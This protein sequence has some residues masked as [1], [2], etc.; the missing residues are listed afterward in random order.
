[1]HKLNLAQKTE[2]DLLFL[3]VEIFS[4]ADFLKNHKLEVI[5]LFKF[6]QSILVKTLDLPTLMATKIRAVFH[7]KWEK[8]DKSGKTL[9]KAKG[10]DYF[11]LMWYLQKGVKPNL[12]SIENIKNKEDLKEKLAQIV[13]KVDSK[14]IQL[15]LEPFI[16]NPVF[17]RDLSKNIKLVLKRELSGL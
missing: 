1:L 16:D 9:I 14:S 6:N 2:S 8:T 7:R 5:P 17:V 13:E 11:D 12:D 3:K 4:R 10:R 15:D